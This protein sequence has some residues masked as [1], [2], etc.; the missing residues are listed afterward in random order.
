MNKVFAA[1]RKIQIKQIF[2]AF[3]L[4]TLLF[5]TQ[6]CSSVDAKSPDSTYRGGMNQYSDVDPRSKDV[7]AAAKLKAKGLRDNAEVNVIDQTGSL[8]GNTR[9]TLDK[10]GENLEDFGKNVKESTGYAVDKAQDSAE[11]FAEGTKRG[12]QNIKENTSNAF[13]KVTNNAEEA[14]KD[15]KINAQRAATDARL[16]TERAAEDAG[17]AVQRTIRDAVN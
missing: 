12:I 1:I 17:N 7:E 10:K 13:G 8:S 2:T 16:G 15:A 5:I 6:A 3:V 11:D 14:A 4:G 9:R